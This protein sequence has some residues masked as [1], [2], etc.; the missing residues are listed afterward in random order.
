MSDN[1]PAPPTPLHG[2]N[3]R[4][5]PTLFDSIVELLEERGLKQGLTHAAVIGVLA[6]VQHFYISEVFKP[7][8]PD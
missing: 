4:R 3:D 7:H 1:S 8:E 6:S 5:V 2:G